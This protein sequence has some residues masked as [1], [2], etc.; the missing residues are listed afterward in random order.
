MTTTTC[1]SMKMINWHKCFYYSRRWKREQDKSNMSRGYN[2]P[3]I[4]GTLPPP[5]PSYIPSKLP[6]SWV[7]QPSPAY[8]RWAGSQ[9]IYAV[10]YS[11]LTRQFRP[12]T[13]VSGVQHIIYTRPEQKQKVY[14]CIQYISS[15]LNQNN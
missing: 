10:S 11:K 2:G 15:V 6:P 7:P 14:R 5:P 3:Y 12:K 1:F 13:N 8:P 4:V 9:N